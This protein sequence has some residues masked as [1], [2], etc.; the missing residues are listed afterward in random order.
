M[1]PAISDARALKGVT[2]D[3]TDLELRDGKKVVIEVG[4]SITS[5]PTLTRS[6][7]SSSTLEVPIF[8]P[9]LE[10]L[11]KTLLS[12]KF[13]ASI[14]GLRFRFAE[15]AKTGADVSLV[16]EDQ[17]IARLKE[18]RGPKKAFRAKLTRAEFV[19]GLVE[20]LK[21][22]VKIYCPQLE[23]KQ[24]LEKREEEVPQNE[25]QGKAAA[26]EAAE[27]GGKGIG[28]TKGLNIEGVPLT[29]S[30][31]ALANTALGI[32]HKVGAKFQVQVALIAAL[33]DESTLGD[34]SQNV[35]AAEQEIST[36]GAPVGS[37]EEE[38]SGF[39]TGKPHWTE[40]TAI[41]YY[42]AHP[43]A[44]FYE[45][46]QAVQG[47]ATSD[48][49]NYARYAD[50]ARQ[51]VE[52]FGGVTAA[53]GEAGV[54]TTSE[55]VTE[56]Y[57]FAVGKKESYWAAIQRLASEVN[58]KAFVV[59]GRFF[60]I[61]EPELARGQVQLAIEREPGRRTPSP[62][63]VIDVDFEYNV[64]LPVTEATLTVFAEHW[65]LRPGAVVTLAGYGPASL[66]AGD[67]PPEKGA[68]FGLSSAVKASTHEGK[69][70][71]LVS[72]VECPLAGDPAKRILTVTLVKPTQPLPEKAASTTT[73][74][75]GVDTS[76]GGVIGNAPQHV[77]ELAKQAFT[78]RGTTDWKGVTIAKW[79]YPALLWAE[80]N[81]G[82]TEV[83]SGYRPGIDSHTASGA[84]EHQGDDYSSG[85][86]KGAIDFG[87]FVDATGREHR[88]SFLD[89]LHKGYPGPMLIKATGFADDGHCSAT[90]S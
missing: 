85:G 11:E 8:D 82:N 28:D 27:V 57:S 71:Y 83:T 13:D 37:A 90:G 54:G 73:K 29:P 41:A 50:E 56:P 35:L 31:E 24:P 64:N 75:T 2:A 88:E 52:A 44:T 69:G 40:I 58:W 34:A 89:S 32:A 86:E 25:R 39:L 16:F 76:A 61:S 5:A 15:A 14:D 80:E 59:E 9:G 33:I 78:V 3:I 60:F 21:P 68:K 38:I 51:I 20:E 48:G 63:A 62:H 53:E 66:G 30:Q 65:K 18:L 23:E 42:N 70:R 55:T 10:I 43:E 84:S 74:A 47:S 77:L 45:I 1:S 79:I 19:C 4:G 81:G 72:K 36:E 22:P 67:A 49:S 46:A 87:G 12:E 6:M 7:E 17:V 26:K